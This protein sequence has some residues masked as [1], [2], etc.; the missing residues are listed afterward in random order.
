ME[1]APLRLF[2]LGDFE[3]RWGSAVLRRADWRRRKAAAL[4]QRLAL[5]RRLLKE[6]AIEFLWPGWDPEAGANN[7]Y[8][9]IYALRQTLDDALGDGAAEAA[10]TFEGGILRLGAA[11]WVDAHAF[12]EHVEAAMAAPPD[13]RRDLLE[14]ALAHYGGDLLPDARYADWTPAWRTRLRRRYRKAC[15][16][17]AILHREAGTYDRAVALLAPLLEDEP[18]DEPVHRELMRAY[19]RAGRRAAALR[20]YEQCADALATAF[21]LPPNAQTQAVYARIRSGE[22]APPATPAEAGAAPE[23]AATMP[24]CDREAELRLVAERLHRGAHFTAGRMPRRRPS[25]ARQVHHGPF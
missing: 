2:V 9:T 4:L 18:T 12:E 8:R 19:A 23:A 3:I 24:F 16:E 11:V 13:Q 10:F 5:E 6:Q 25:R 15:L 7:L 21:D 22:L 1:E 20:Q 14:A 17:L